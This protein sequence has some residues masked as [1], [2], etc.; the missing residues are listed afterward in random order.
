MTDRGKCDYFDIWKIFTALS[1]KITFCL[2]FTPYIFVRNY[3]TTKR[4]I[5]EGRNLMH[6]VRDL[7]D[8]STNIYDSSTVA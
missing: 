4:H 8:G 6:L 5:T 2:G 7:Y 1:I 3:R